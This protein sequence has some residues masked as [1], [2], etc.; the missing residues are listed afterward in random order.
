MLW[1]VP[2]SPLHDRKFIIYGTEKT[3][4]EQG[5]DRPEGKTSASAAYAYMQSASTVDG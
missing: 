5:V 3:R 1:I 4:R 2:R